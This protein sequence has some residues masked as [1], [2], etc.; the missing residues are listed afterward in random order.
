[1]KAELWFEQSG[2]SLKNQVEQF[3]D[4]SFGGISRF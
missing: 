4:K 2:L 1:M 3:F